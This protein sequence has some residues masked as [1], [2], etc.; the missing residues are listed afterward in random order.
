MTIRH[1]R[2]RAALILLL[3]PLAIGP[4]AAAAEGPE[5]AAAPAAV[6]SSPADVAVGNLVAFLEG[7]GDRPREREHRRDHVRSLERDA[8]RPNERQEQ[9]GDAERTERARGEAGRRPTRPGAPSMPGGPG[10]PGRRPFDAD[11][12]R[13]GRPGMP[14]GRGPSLQRF[15]MPRPPMPRGAAGEQ[16]KVQAFSFRVAPDGAVQGGPIPGGPVA[17]GKDGAGSPQGKGAIVLS[18]DGDVIK[19]GDGTIKLDGLPGIGGMMKGMVVPPA[20]GPDAHAEVRQ[21]LERIL[22]KVNAIEARLGGPGAHGQ[23]HAGPHQPG[24]Q[25]P[26]FQNQGP[27]QPGPQPHMQHQGPHQ[28]GPGGPPGPGPQ[29][30]PGPGGHHPDEINRR[31]EE[32]ARE[33]HARVEELKRGIAEKLQGAGRGEEEW[34]AWH[35]KLAQTHEQLQ[36]RFQDVRRRFA[37]QQE[38][39]E[40]LEQEVRRLREE[41]GQP[42]GERRERD[43]ERPREQ[44]PRRPAADGPSDPR[45]L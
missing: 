1:H 21:Q 17:G 9:A 44:E 45:P 28:P 36:E 13:E 29:P 12:A 3:P 40:R 19:L 14:P 37:E 4:W 22:D 24:P 25:G 34:R 10:R 6:E 33:L 11:G 5:P 7:E 43:R 16:P 15:G 38:R 26:I 2:R 27:H 41:R 23:P 31:F 8:Q 18:I 39:I 32:H 30:G 42:A 20:S 35:Q